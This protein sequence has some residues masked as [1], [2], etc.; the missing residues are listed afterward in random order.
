MIGLAKIA[1]E[2]DVFDPQEFLRLKSMTDYSKSHTKFEEQKLKEK[3]NKA[4]L[5]GMLLG[6]LS[7][8]GLGL[9]SGFAGKKI[10]K[11]LPEEVGLGGLGA[12]FGGTGG[13]LIGE[14]LANNRF[15][16]KNKELYQN[17]DHA[18]QFHSHNEK[19]LF[20]YANRLK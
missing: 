15:K 6:G 2:N 18:K 13:I 9:A 12:A 17:V 11:K 19:K 10:M 16:E 8:A 1:S 7:G 3:N 5:D 14:G 4:K 20:D